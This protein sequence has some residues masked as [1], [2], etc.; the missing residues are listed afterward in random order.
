MV[1]AMTAMVAFAEEDVQKTELQVDATAADD[2]VKIEEEVVSV[3]AFDEDEF[4]E[5]DDF[6]TE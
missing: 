2:A 4:V 5:E 1:I 6:S 3:S